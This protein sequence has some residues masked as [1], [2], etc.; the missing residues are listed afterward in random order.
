MSRPARH[1]EAG[2]TLVEM[3]VAL[4][5]FAVIAAAGFAVLGQVIRVQAATGDR[6]DRLASIQRSMY[7][8]TQDFLQTTG[9]S[10]AA[11]GGGVAFRRSAGP[12]ELSV[13]Y[14]LEG[15]SFV[16][17]LSGDP[18]RAAHGRRCSTASAASAGNS[19]TPA[20][21]GA[22][23]GRPARRRPPRTPPPSRSS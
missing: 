12:G 5:L 23:T 13:R 9:G 18:A 4:A 10:L 20:T 14:A 2:L 8:L 21:A 17:E 11:S 15:S 6:L 16:R 3:L 7:V 22:P 19:T 1:P